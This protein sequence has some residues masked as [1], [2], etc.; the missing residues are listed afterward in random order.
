[1][2]M[3]SSTPGDGSTSRP[4]SSHENKQTPALHPDSETLQASTHNPQRTILGLRWFLVCT[5]IYSANFLYGLDATIAA[6]IQA[7]VSQD[8][9]EVQKLGWLGFGFGLG[10][11][12]SILPVGKAYAMFDTKWMFLASLS[13]FSIGSALCGAA[14]T[15]NVLILGRVLAGSGGAGMYL[16]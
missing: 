16:G 12:A 1:M 10:S 13:L 8:F 14:P 15:M 5:A 11:T 6:D 7:P 4:Q 9:G 3:D 2:A